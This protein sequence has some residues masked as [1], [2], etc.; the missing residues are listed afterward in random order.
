M[1]AYPFIRKRISS[2]I[3]IPKELKLLCE[4]YDNNRY[5]ISGDFDFYASNWDMLDY[6][7][8]I[9]NIY[10]RIGIFGIT[11]DYSF[12]ALWLDE[13]E[14]QKVVH[15][16]DEGSEL[17]ILADNFLDFLRLLAIGYD[18]IGFARQSMT[19]QEWNTIIEKDKNYGVNKKFQEWVKNEFNTQ[20]PIRGNEITN[21]KDESFKNWLGQNPVWK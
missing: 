6:W 16:G 14:N 7:Y 21:F 4:W 2:N 18:E 20:I 13:D 12:Y 1:K 19:V 11:S 5:P 17:Y 3:S 10:D 15:I 8:G 9:D